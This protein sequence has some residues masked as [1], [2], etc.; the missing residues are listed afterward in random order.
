MRQKI[1][2]TTKNECTG[3]SAC[4]S[5][6]PKGCISMKEDKEGFLQPI[7]DH[8]KCIKCHKCEHICPILNKE[9]I[10]DRF[11]TKAFAAIYK[12]ESIRKESSSGGVFFALAQWVIN[13]GGVVFGARWNEAWEVVHDFADTLDGVRAFMKSK[14]VQS[15]IGDTYL[16][17]K[18]FLDAGRWVL[19]SGTPCQLAGLRAFLGKGYEHLLQVDLIC[20]GVPSPGVWR[21]YLESYF[22]NENILSVNMREKEIG[23]D[24]YRIHVLTN[25]STYLVDKASNPYITGFLNNTYLRRSC[26]HCVFRQYHRA[27]D[28]TI[29]DYWGVKR[30]CPEMYDGRG[31]SVVFCHT[32]IGFSIINKLSDELALLP[33]EKVRAIRSNEAMESNF[34]MPDKRARFYRLFKLTSSFKHSEYPIS[35]NT[36]PMSIKRYLKRALHDWK[37]TRC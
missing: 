25:R 11:E 17:A 31:T 36:I 5:V 37:V 6:C 8:S 1:S 26:Y 22:P 29:A 13:Q 10:T 16:Q 20:H 23:W 19:F 32:E 4:V 9:S 34:A 35:H 14:Y 12:D 7:I 28:L 27:S 30:E 3:C 15:R 33:Q 21:K 2:L 18:K 24:K